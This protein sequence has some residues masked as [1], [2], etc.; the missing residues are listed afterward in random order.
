MTSP[1]LLSK[2]NVSTDSL[3]G[4]DSVVGRHGLKLNNKV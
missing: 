2:G 3:S 4:G 1:V